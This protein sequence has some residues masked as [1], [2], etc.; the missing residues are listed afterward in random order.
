MRSR[1]SSEDGGRRRPAI[2]A[3]HHDVAGPDR[4]GWG[5][6]PG[7]VVL[8]QMAD[9]SQLSG[10]PEQRLVVRDP[11]PRGRRHPQDH[12]RGPRER[13]RHR[14]D[15]RPHH[16]GVLRRALGLHE[17][18]PRTRS[19]DRC[20]RLDAH[21]D[22]ERPGL[23]GRNVLDQV[24]PVDHALGD[25][26]LARPAGEVSDREDRASVVALDEERARGVPGV[27]DPHEERDP[28]AGL[29]F[30]G[31]ALDEP[32]HA[33][34][35]DRDIGDGR[36]LTRRGR[37]GAAREHGDRERARQG[38][39]NDAGA[40]HG[41]RFD[42]TGRTVVKRQSTVRRAEISSGRPSASILPSRNR[43]T[44]LE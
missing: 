18:P 1:T 20:L 36:T 30:A 5:V 37:R 13:R 8:E 38:V 9:R 14:P 26:L 4:V 44:R 17:E 27:L 21:A 43:I 22:P 28:E 40:G 32:L 2:A 19:V 10:R 29:L 31:A 42:R 11:E 6:E 16:V 33:G 24:G 15:G 35:P 12:A 3:L 25:P 41:P 34:R 7:A 23:A 39:P